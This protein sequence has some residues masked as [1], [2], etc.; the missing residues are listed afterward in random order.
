MEEKPKDHYWL[1]S[2]LIN[3]L[4]N[5]S[6]VFFGFAGFYILVRVLSKHDFGVWTLFMSVTSILEAIRSGLIQNALVKYLSSAEKSEHVK[7]TSASTFISGLITIFALVMIVTMAPYLSRLWSSPE[8][9]G[10]LY[11]YLL[12][13]FLSGVLTQFNAIEQANLKFN[14]IFITNF[15]RQASF[16]S[17]VL[18]C[19]LIN[20]EMKLIYLV[21]VQVFSLILSVAV[22]YRYVRH[23]F[24]LSTS[25]SKV[26]M[27]KLFGYGKYAF[28]TSVSS[29]LSGT[30]DQMML[31]ALLSPAASGAFNIAV[32]I[33]NLIDIPG[34]AIAVVVFPQSSKRMELEGKS[35]IKY[36]YEKS[37]G[38]TLALVLPGV[39]F[40]YF[41]SDYVIDFI[42]G[43]KYQ[44]S[45]PLLHITLLYCLLIPYGRQFGTI[46]DSIGKTKI[47]F[48]VVVG[49]TIINLGLNYLFIVR[50]G[51]KG[52]AY[53]TLVSNVIGFAVAQ[54]ILRKEVGV[55]LWNTLIYLVRFY[56]EFF[57]KYVKPA[58]RKKSGQID[59]SEIK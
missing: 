32:R 21:G 12:V 55:N 36:L 3:V 42:A 24:S 56:P 51:V 58:L 6:G 10:L 49:T 52:A 8:L 46:L 37:V 43:A 4:Q 35:A 30:V 50:F 11:L 29:M 39:L 13:F 2:G 59:H 38:T 20:F 26:W 45:I 40:L 15:I 27:G 41:F 14:G 18:I 23:N 19:Y 34:N 5:F 9:V 22:A 28:G 25:I 47:T 53:A 48:L 57:E 44:D 17:F 7:I 54:V 16:F 1:K 31:G 33:T